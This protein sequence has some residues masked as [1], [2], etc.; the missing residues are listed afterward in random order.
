[1]TVVLRLSVA[2]NSWN[3]HQQIVK[4]K[5]EFGVFYEENPSDYIV[6]ASAPQK[7]NSNL[8]ACNSLKIILT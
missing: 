8:H 6:N 2:L 1:M 3:L 4:W 5:P 7:N